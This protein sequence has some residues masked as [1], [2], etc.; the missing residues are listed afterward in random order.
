MRKKSKVLLLLCLMLAVPLMAVSVKAIAISPSGTTDGILD[1]PVT[2]E[3]SG[4]NVSRTYTIELNDATVSS[5][6]APSTDGTFSFSV[7]PATE[8]RNKVEVIDDVTSLVVLT[9]Y[10]QAQDIIAMIINVMTLVISIG[11]ILSIAKEI[12]V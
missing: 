4:A 11:L 7:T 9:V 6:V 1:F 5:A 3:V 8:G 10:V 2:F 12:K